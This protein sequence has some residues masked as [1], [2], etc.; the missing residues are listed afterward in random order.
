[1]RQRRERR[2]VSPRMATVARFFG[3]RYSL[4]RDAYVLRGIGGRV[5]PVLKTN[6]H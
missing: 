2:T 5:G 4:S 6:V 1:M 3:F